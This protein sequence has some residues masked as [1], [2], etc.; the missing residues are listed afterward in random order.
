MPCPRAPLKSS[1]VA[2]GTPSESSSR[3]RSSTSALMSEAPAAEAG[4]EA[5]A[6]GTR[7]EVA[8]VGPQADEV[9]LRAAGD[10]QPDLQH[11]VGHTRSGGR[12]L[13][14]CVCGEQVIDG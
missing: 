14:V 5:V 10:P 6:D 11:R 9:V 7:A 2:S 8:P 4:E 1:G 3:R 13:P 12:S